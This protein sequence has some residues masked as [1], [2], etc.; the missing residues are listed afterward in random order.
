MAQQTPDLTNLAAD[1]WDFEEWIRREHAGVGQALVSPTA[2][3]AACWQLSVTATSSLYIREI[4]F[5]TDTAISF[6]LWETIGLLALPGVAAF[7][8]HVN[9][10]PPAEAVFSAG[11]LAP[12]A[13][14]RVLLQGWVPAN[15]YGSILGRLKLL[16]FNNVVGIVLQTAPV[17]ANCSATFGFISATN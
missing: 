10:A 17:V 6:T 4:L 8:L 9:V 1:L 15:F 2:A 12:P 5:S 14:S 16:T 13:T 3:L 7:N 11:P